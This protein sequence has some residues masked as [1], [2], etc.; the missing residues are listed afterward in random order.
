MT[1]T[2]GAPSS[3]RTLTLSG[4]E[5]DYQRKRL[6]KWEREVPMTEQVR[7]PIS[8]DACRDLVHAV[9]DDY[10]IDPPPK[11]TD[12]RGCRHARGSLKE[13]KLPTWARSPWTVLHECAHG[14]NDK[15]RPWAPG[16]GPEFVRLYVTLLDQYYD[17]PASALVLSARSKGLHVAAQGTTP[18]RLSR[19]ERA[20]RIAVKKRHA[21]GRVRMLLRRAMS[22]LYVA[23]E[24]IAGVNGKAV[25]RRR[26][27]A[28]ADKISESL[29]RDAPIEEA[30]Q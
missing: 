9:Y 17:V 25:A 20:A 8:L 23:G 19:E 18:H 21:M 13:V 22:D 3:A 1:A 2:E 11:V 10:G 27:V 30:T 5:K 26:I 7:L 28:L 16:H 15:V 24:V 6:Y 14:L 12:G 29:E 4:R